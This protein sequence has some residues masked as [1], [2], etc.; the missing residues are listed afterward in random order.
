MQEILK[1]NNEDSVSKLVPAL[2]VVAT[3]IGNLGDITLRAI[4]ILKNC[5]F[6]ICEDTRVTG[7]LLNHLGIKK[8]FIIYN[9]H[10]DENV[11]A[12]VLSQ[13]LQGKSLA[14]VS[15]AGTPLICDP[16]YKLVELLRENDCKIFAIPGACSAI[17][18]LS[19]SGI[20]SDRFMFCGFVPHVAKTGFF[21]ELVNIESSLIF[22][23]SPSR[24]VKTLKIMNEI[25]GNRMA[26]VSREITKFYEQTKKDSL[27]NLANFYE[28][29]PPRGEIVILL[30]A[31]LK[32]GEID[33]VRIDDLLQKGMGT[34]KPKELVAM[35]ADELKLGKKEVYARMLELAAK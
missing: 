1:E 19:V 14:L 23:E 28:T 7:K 16:G 20:G 9:D 26:A 6:V 25:F 29:N 17:A 22:F 24:L 34:M 13:I 8:T 32:K 21:K 27:E 12:K 11:R 2:Y 18:A 3:P 4:E 10:S 30:S 5:D 35:V 33:D 15:D 31:P